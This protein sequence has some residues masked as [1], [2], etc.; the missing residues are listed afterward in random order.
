M[1]LEM[2]AGNL[3]VNVDIEDEFHGDYLGVLEAVKTLLYELNNFDN[4]SIVI[5]S[6]DEDEDQLDEDLD[7]GLGDGDPDADPK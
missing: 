7:D 1:K 4:V 2:H 5:Q 6:V 3:E